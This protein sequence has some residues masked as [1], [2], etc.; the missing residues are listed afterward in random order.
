MLQV[1]LVSVS[2][3]SYLLPSMAIKM[4]LKLQSPFQS[5][6]NS[7]IRLQSHIVVN[8]AII[9]FFFEILKDGW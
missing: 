9:L 1:I 2:E 6:N 7:H 5:T 3:H 4:G 8:E